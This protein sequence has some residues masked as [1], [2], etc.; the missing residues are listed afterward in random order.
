VEMCGLLHS[1]M[2]EQVKVVSQSDFNAWITSQG[3]HV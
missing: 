1:Y 3:G 2:W